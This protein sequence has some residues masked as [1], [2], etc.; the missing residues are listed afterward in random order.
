ME[1]LNAVDADK[2]VPPTQSVLRDVI[3]KSKVVLV[4]YYLPY[5]VYLKIRGWVNPFPLG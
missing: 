2:V 5:E 1:V 3:P 4:L